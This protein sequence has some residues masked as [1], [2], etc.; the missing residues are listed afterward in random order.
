MHFNSKVLRVKW[1][2]LHV[3]CA[4]KVADWKVVM[5][6]LPAH[7]ISRLELLNVSKLPDGSTARCKKVSIF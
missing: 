3:K 7:G 2:N 1:M 5:F 4:I 6:H